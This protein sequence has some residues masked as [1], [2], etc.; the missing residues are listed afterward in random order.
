[1]QKSVCD[2]IT[3]FR[4][5]LKASARGHPI[6]NVRFGSK[7]DIC[8]AKAHVRSRHSLANADSASKPVTIYLV[9]QMMKELPCQDGNHC[10]QRYEQQNFQ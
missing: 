1:M 8:I 2:A 5:T 4:R 6:T 10:H 7:A 9:A 3:K